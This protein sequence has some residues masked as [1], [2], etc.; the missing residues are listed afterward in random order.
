MK[1]LSKDLKRGVVK[2]SVENQDDFWY[3]SQLIDPDDIVEAR[4]FRKIKLEG[5]RKSEI[6]KKPVTISLRAEKV[7]F[8]ESSLRISGIIVEGPDDVPRGSHHTITVEEN[9][10][11]TLTKSHWL[12]YQVERLDEACASKAP[13]IIICVFDR[14]EAFIA[15]LKKYGYELLARLRGTVAKKA[16]AS[17]TKDFYAEIIT[18]LKEYDARF[19]PERIVLASPAFWKEELLKVLT[20]D[21]LRKKFVLATVSSVDEGAINEA[22]ARDETKDA[23]RSAK[24]ASELR[25]VQELLAVIA[26]GGAASYGLSMTEQAANSGAVQTLLVSD[27]LIK[28]AREEGTFQRV[29][30]VFRAVD[31]SGGKIVIVSEEHDGGKKLAGLGGIAGLLRYRLSES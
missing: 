18:A 13:S 1:L 16:M 24:F 20:D 30:A 26:R 28:R 19:H 22:I 4:T 17:Q 27:R 11:L 12:S 7:E 9:A 25:L 29:D 21:A 10:P 5:D 6:I 3:L 8:T 31:A 15:L 2:L 23:L 14:E